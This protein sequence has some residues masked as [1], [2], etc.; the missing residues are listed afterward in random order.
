M[1]VK[2]I[3]RDGHHDDPWSTAHVMNTTAIR[4]F[5]HRGLRD[6]SGCKMRKKKMKKARARAKRAKLFLSLLIMQILDF[7]VVIA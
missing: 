2:K 4:A 3:L 6:E 7:V 1:Y 5:S